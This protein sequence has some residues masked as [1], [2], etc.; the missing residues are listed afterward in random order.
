[1][2]DM[3]RLLSR[4]AALQQEANA[5]RTSLH[6]D[7]LLRTVGEPVLVGSAA[8]GLMVW[9]DL[10]LTVVCDSLDLGGVLDIGRSLGSHPDVHT[11]TVRNDT[12][13][14]NTEPDRYP[15]GL[16]LGLRYR[17]EG[18]AEW[19]LDLWFVDEPERQPDLRHVRTL[20]SLL[21]EQS[22]GAILAIKTAWH[23]RPES[24]TGVSSADI[25]AAVVED[26]VGDIASFEAWLLRRSR[27]EEVHERQPG[28]A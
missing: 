23:R 13:R 18:C 20:P 8:L 25:Y 21:T 27:D 4:Q 1:M 2:M 24:G 3:Q 12:G 17:Q 26:G 10:D 14:W 5:V 15:D 11:L 9:E 6:L 16:Y 7:H 19:K 28:G 22:R